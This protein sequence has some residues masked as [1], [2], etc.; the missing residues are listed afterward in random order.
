MSPFKSILLFTTLVSLATLIFYQAAFWYHWSKARGANGEKITQQ[1]IY[2]SQD[3]NAVLTLKDRKKWLVACCIFAI[4]Y[5]LYL[6][7]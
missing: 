7:V 1:Q 3:G 2:K 5:F 4:S 6:F